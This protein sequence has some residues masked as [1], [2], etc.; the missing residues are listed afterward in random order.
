MLVKDSFTSGMEATREK[1]VRVGGCWGLLGVSG[2]EEAE[3]EVSVADIARGGGDGG[4]EEERKGR[5]DFWREGGWICNR[6]IRLNTGVPPIPCDC[7]RTLGNHILRI[8]LL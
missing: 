7:T 5:W 1:I 6:F 2:V 3:V 4:G 8:M